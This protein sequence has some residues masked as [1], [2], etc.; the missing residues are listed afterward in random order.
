MQQRGKLCIEKVFVEMSATVSG[1]LVLRTRD[2]SLTLFW[3]RR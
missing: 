2:D 3:E 1:L